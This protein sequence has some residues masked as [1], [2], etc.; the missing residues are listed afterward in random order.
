MSAY[1]LVSRQEEIYLVSGK[2]IN[3]PAFS[4]ATF[5]L[6]DATKTTDSYSWGL[7]AVVILSYV[8]VETSATPQDPLFINI[9]SSESSITPARVETYDP[10]T[11]STNGGFYR[12]VTVNAEETFPG[13]FDWDGKLEFVTGSYAARLYGDTKTYGGKNPIIGISERGSYLRVAEW[14]SNSWQIEVNEIRLAESDQITVGSTIF[15]GGES[16]TDET[17]FDSIKWERGND[18]DRSGLIDEDEWELIDAA[19]NSGYQ[20][21]DS[22]AGF[23]LRVSGVR[24]GTAFV[25]STSPSA[26]A[27]GTLFSPIDIDPAPNRF[28]EFALPGTSI[29][30]KAYAYDPNL[31]ADEVLYELKTDYGGL[32]EIDSSTGALYVGDVTGLDYESTFGLGEYTVDIVATG[33]GGIQQSQQFTF[34]I[35]DIVDESVGE[36]KAVSSTDFVGVS[37]VAGEGQF[38]GL[39]VYAENLSHIDSISYYLVDD[40]GGAFKIV[41]SQSHLSAHPTARI[42]V[43]D[44]AQLMQFGSEPIHLEII[45]E[46]SNGS[47]N[48]AV[49]QLPLLPFWT[50]TVSLNFDEPIGRDISQYWHTPD[51]KLDVTEALKDLADYWGVDA[52]T[53]RWL[54]S[55]VSPGLG[56][57]DYPS[58]LNMDSAVQ[59]VP[60]RAWEPPGDFIYTTTPSDWYGTLSATYELKGWKENQPNGYYDNSGKFVEW[61][62]LTVKFNVTINEQNDPPY[63]NQYTYQY[64]WLTEVEPVSF[65]E[66]EVAENK[67]LEWVF[68][69]ELIQ[70]PE[71]D[72]ISNISLVALDGLEL[73]DWLSFDGS[74]LRADPTSGEIG[75]YLLEFQITDSRGA[76]SAEFLSLEVVN[77][78][79]PPPERWTQSSI[80]FSPGATGTDGT[81]LERGAYADNILLISEDRWPADWGGGAGGGH[82]IILA[83]DGTVSKK[84]D[85]LAD[86]PEFQGLNAAIEL[87]DG[88]VAVL[89]QNTVSSS[90]LLKIAT[91]D[92]VNGLVDIVTLSDQA[93]WPLNYPPNDL[94]G[95]KIFETLENDGFYIINTCHG[96]PNYQIAVAK[97]DYFG[98][99]ITEFG[100]G[101]II[102]YSAGNKIQGFSD[103]TLDASGNL[104]VLSSQLENGSYEGMPSLIKIDPNGLLTEINHLTQ[105]ASSATVG[106]AS[107][108]DINGDPKIYA[109]YTTD[110]YDWVVKDPNHTLTIEIDRF[111]VDGSLDTSFG[112]GGRVSFQKPNTNTWVAEVG[113][114]LIDVSPNGDIAIAYIVNDG[115]VDITR[116]TSEGEINLID[117]L[118][119]DKTSLDGSR[120]PLWL[121]LGADGA[122]I[123]GSYEQPVNWDAISPR[124]IFVDQFNFNE[125]LIY[126]T[127]GED[128]LVGSDADDRILGL[129]GDDWFELSRGFDHIDGG[130][131]F[132]RIDLR[133]LTQSVVFVATQGI[134]Y[135]AE[136]G[137]TTFVNIERV[138]GGT[139]NDTFI[140]H[141]GKDHPYYTTFYETIDF[142]FTGDGGDDYIEGVGDAD[143][144]WYGGSPA[145]IQADLETGEVTG[146]EGIDTLV[147]IEWIRGSNYNDT[148]LGSAA[149][150]IFFDDALNDTGTPD[151]TIGGADYI[152]G[153]GGVDT[154]MFHVYGALSDGNSL[155]FSGVVVDMKNGIATDSAGNTD[156]FLNIENIVG[157][158]MSDEILGDDF[159]NWIH[160]DSGNDT[161]TVGRGR[162]FARL[163]GDNDTVT[164]TADGVWGSRYSATHMSDASSVGT[165]ERISIAGKNRYEDVIW[166]EEG[167]DKVLLSDEADVLVVE[168]RYSGY[169]TQA[170]VNSTGTALNTNA[171]RVSGFEEVFAGGGDDVIDFTSVA[172]ASVVSN[173]I[174][175][176]GEA[177]NDVLWASHGNDVLDGGDGDDILNGGVGND[178]LTGGAG[179]D[180]YEFTATSGHDTI[181][182]FDAANDVIHIY[183]RKTDTKEVTMTG[184]TITWGDVE[185]QLSNVAIGDTLKF[186]ENIFWMTV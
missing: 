72:G 56:A 26:V 39:E 114:D 18:F 3:I 52:V 57:I 159:D 78:D 144:I 110:E 70:D 43:N 150:N 14:A 109:A 152:D 102:R 34:Q 75:S 164:L 60:S 153:R 101:G 165:N 19:T 65:L 15:L 48:S 20:V 50:Q 180:I 148:L 82:L 62:K 166:G 21:S 93:Q 31:S 80:E 172:Y 94:F 181:T 92:L 47:S 84:I 131:G 186:G 168:D 184:D 133:P 137:Q 83:P 108:L 6:S 58:D 177:G 24:D 151:Y 170:L 37:I 183:A 81:I 147:G 125:S 7:N 116:I 89:G 54:G 134:A 41:N 160:S 161:V 46:S 149:D 100:E 157:T 23:F 88:R 145:G 66:V 135:G 69:Y 67:R 10:I 163:G 13:W 77:V 36:I 85:V 25:S 45:A 169:N 90:L 124:E 8:Q 176:Y 12:V 120:V 107:F 136:I 155:G 59:L 154:L 119:I 29:G 63:I 127:E 22:D 1:Y 104:W 32:L 44:P 68:P 171:A 121:S 61:P 53:Y 16:V 99:L 143:F 30:I 139:G 40:Y 111:N 174:K 96:D 173:G 98:N 4:S 27:G 5:T 178:T 115:F 130:D 185:I 91:I 97:I 33:Y 28:S 38:T 112:D 95:A 11:N 64:P 129:G 86:L 106:V 51:R 105:Y 141:V 126:G 17:V 71:G 123:L 55:T 42:L 158:S 113:R 146:G 117:E 76:S 128:H 2:D 142:S 175:I 35:T 9:Y 79:G 167:Y 49:F 103:A 73:R 179:A 156:R 162:D 138:I 182:D 87:S 118:P 74:T 132:D 140:G 122:L